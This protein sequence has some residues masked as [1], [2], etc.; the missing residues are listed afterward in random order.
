MKTFKLF[1]S[2]AWDYDEDY[3]GVVSL[4]YSDYE[5][6]WE[7]LSAPEDRPLQTLL[8]LPKSNRFLVKQLDDRIRQADCVLVLAGMYC[9]HRAWIQSEIEA[10]VEFQRPVIGIA[11]RG[12]GKNPCRGF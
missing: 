6:K 1:I 9:S 10:A 2:H 3:E 4:L 11:P 8:D 7:D 12:A 5:F